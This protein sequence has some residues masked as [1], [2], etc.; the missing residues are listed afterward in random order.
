MVGLLMSRDRYSW[1]KLAIRSSGCLEGGAGG[2][3]AGA[4]GILLYVRDA[5]TETT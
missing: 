2:T 1:G 4:N 3:G 5:F